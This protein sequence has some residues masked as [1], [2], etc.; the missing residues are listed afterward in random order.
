[1]ID[2]Q[3][4]L[5]WCWLLRGK[6]VYPT[7]GYYSIRCSFCPGSKFKFSSCHHATWLQ[8]ILDF[9][10]QITTDNGLADKIIGTKFG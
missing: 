7:T 10:E 2:S 4:F 5:W 1:M 8:Q 9:N 6:V 3:E